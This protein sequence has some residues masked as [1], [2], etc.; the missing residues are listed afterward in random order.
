MPIVRADALAA[1][2]ARI[3]AATGAPA[4][5]ARMVADH[6]VGANLRGHDSHGAIRTASYVALA[7]SG[8][9]HPGAHPH[10]VRESASTAVLDG[11]WNYGQ[12]VAFHAMNLAIAKAR[13]TGVGVVSAFHS[14]HI[15]RVGAYGEQAVAAGMI[16]IGGVNSPGVRL[17]AAYGGA[18]RRLGTNPIMIAMPTTNPAEPFVLDMATSVVAE[19]KL[20]VAVNKGVQVPE[21]WIIDGD[22]RATS[23]PR[24]FYGTG[25]NPTPGALLPVGGATGGYKG[26]G[27]NMA[28]EALSGILSG[29]GTAVKGARGSNGV[30]LMALD[31]ARFTGLDTFVA[32]LAALIAHVQEPPFAPGVNEVLTAGEPERRTMAQR[33]AHGIEL[34]DETWKQIGEAAAS[35]GVS[36]VEIAPRA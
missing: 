25:S 17:T 34:D 8:A 5:E 19:G 35:V 23:E 15:G 14:G 2:E 32:M 29:A 7:Q 28:M 26:F 11:E 4:D 24:D 10:M 33:R 22:G 30:F 12:V 1:Y 9:L 13:D 31:P 20:R 18:H 6:L 16:G 3:F 21:H 36:P 27:L